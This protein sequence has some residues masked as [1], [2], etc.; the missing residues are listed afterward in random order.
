MPQIFRF[1]ILIPHR[2]V[3]GLLEKMRAKLF[4]AGFYGAYSFPPAAPLLR[5]SRPFSREELK[6]FARNIRST[7]NENKG[8]ILSSAPAAIHC[9]GALSFFGPRLNLPVDEV[10]I[11]RPAETKI[12]QRLSPPLLCA[13]LVQAENDPVPETVIASDAA[14]LS[15]RAGALANLSIRPLRPL[16]GEETAYSFEWK[17]GPA[18]WMPRD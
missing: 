12:L 13:A 15:F 18:V 3:R 17:I 1:V 8:K 4:S 6:E 14:A 11:P 2:D 16:D 10:I 5:V 9:P 7:V